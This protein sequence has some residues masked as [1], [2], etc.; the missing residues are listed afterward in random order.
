MGEWSGRLP[1]CV[2]TYTWLAPQLVKGEATM[3][4]ACISVLESDPVILNTHKFYESCLQSISWKAVFH[5][6]LLKPNYMR[7]GFQGLLPVHINKF[8]PPK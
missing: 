3:F 5:F 6:L 7:H 2:S 1:N 8:S 4:S